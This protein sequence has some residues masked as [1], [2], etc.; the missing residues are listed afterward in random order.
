MSGQRSSGGE[1][2]RGSTLPAENTWITIR[3]GR[4]GK[5][6]AIYR[7]YVLESR[8]DAVVTFQPRTPVDRP[9]VVDG[10]TILEPRSPVIWFTYPDK[11]HDIGLFH[12]TNG[13]FTGHYANILTPVDF[14]NQRSWATTDLCL[15]V[16]IPRYG[17]VQLLDEP[18]LDEAES[19]TLITKELADR[20][21]DEA[22]ALM[23]AFRAG[24]WP[25]RETGE[26]SLAR[27]LM[28]CRGGV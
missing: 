24:A 2:G 5:P 6:L 21:R 26:W 22:A 27:A 9:I 12:R 3:Y 4:I 23:F 18:E 10:F 19:G 8:P 7:L 17:D 25:P 13:A 15:D 20:A 14:I 11:L 1:D 28:A 16:W